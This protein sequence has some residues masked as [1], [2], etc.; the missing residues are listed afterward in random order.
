MTTMEQIERPLKTLA[1][2]YGLEWVNVRDMETNPYETWSRI[3]KIEARLKTLEPDVP[4][5][6]E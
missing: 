4:A 1:E 3:G 5:C 6:E 2:R